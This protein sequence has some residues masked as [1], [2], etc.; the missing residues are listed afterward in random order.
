MTWRWKDGMAFLIPPSLHNH[1]LNLSAGYDLENPV[2][3]PQLSPYASYRTLGA[4]YISPSGGM[5]KS[6]EVLRS[7]ALDY[8]SRLESSTIQKEPAI[9]SYL[10]YLLPKLTFP[11]MA[12]TLTEPQCHKIQSPALRALLPKLHLNR[13]MAR[14]KIH[15]PLIYGGMNLPHLYTIQGCDQLKFL[16]GHLRAQDKTCKLILICHGCLQLLV[17]I[18]NFF[19]KRTL[20]NLFLLYL[21]ILAY[22]CMAVH[23]QISSFYNN[24]RCMAPVFPRARRRQSYGIFRF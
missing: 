13:N 14:S 19:F 8:A 7:Y 4:Y 5:E 24:E 15:G 20:P 22:I 11:L 23:E 3:V 9:W 10:L 2:S 1:Q 16:L 21:P 12:L 17:G 6:V 18:T